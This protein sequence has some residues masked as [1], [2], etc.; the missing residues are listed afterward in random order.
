MSAYPCSLYLAVCEMLCAG[1]GTPQHTVVVSTTQ[2]SGWS[3]HGPDALA[4]PKALDVRR[5]F[6]E[7]LDHGGANLHAERR[8]AKVVVPAGRTRRVGDGKTRVA[9][10]V[11]EARGEVAR[12]AA[13]ELRVH[14]VRRERGDVA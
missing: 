6:T 7:I 5:K 8:A 3:C 12:G 14:G 9:L 11:V 10:E 4:V 2:C 13:D 1:D